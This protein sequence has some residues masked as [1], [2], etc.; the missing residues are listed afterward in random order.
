MSTTSPVA[1]RASLPSTPQQLPPPLE[2]LLRSATTYGWLVLLLTFAI[3]LYLPLAVA[4]INWIDNVQ[5]LWPVALL[6]V[7]V[8]VL[9]ALGRPHA[10]RGFVVGLVGG[11]LG[12]FTA[13]GD[14]IP[15]PARLAF[16][17][18]E[19]VRW[20]ISRGSAVPAGDNPPARMW[21][22]GSL[23]AQTFAGHL[24]S[25]WKLGGIGEA[26]ID[27]RIFLFLL[28]I[29]SWT[30][31]LYFAWALYSHTPPLVAV[32]PPGVVLVTFVVLGGQGGK[33]VYLFLFTALVLILRIHVLSLVRAWN[34]RNLD[35]PTTVGPEV[36]VT[37]LLFTVLV[38]GLALVL[39]AVPQNPLAVRFWGVFNGPWSKLETNVGEAFTGVRHHVGGNGSHDLFLG[40]PLSYGQNQVVM[41][42]TT[43]EPPPPD[44]SEHA[45]EAEGYVEPEH[46]LAGATY[47]DY[48]GKSWTLGKTAGVSRTGVPIGPSGAPEYLGA[49]VAGGSV[50]TLA[51]NQPVVTPVPSGDKVVQQIERVA[52]FGDSLLYAYNQAVTVNQ[53]T[54]VHSSGGLPDSID[55]K[56]GAKKYTVVSIEPGPSAQQLRA[57][58]TKYA[59]W[60]A[61]YLAKPNTPARVAQLAQQWAGTATNPYDRAMN[62]E[63]ELRKIP[64][65]TDITPPP[66]GQDAVDYFLFTLKRGYCEYYA[67]AMV[68]ML[69]D[70]GVPARVVTGYATTNYDRAKAAYEVD[71]SDAHAWV[72]IYFPNVGWL[73]FE[74]TPVN[75]ELVRPDSTLPDT[76]ISAIV[77]QRQPATQGSRLPVDPRAIA[78]VIVALLATLVT[79]TI[80]RQWEAEL[81]PR[82]YVR[83]VYGRMVRR[84]S[85]F[86]LRK[87][88]DETALEYGYRLAAEFELTAEPLALA[89]RQIATLYVLAQ[90]AGATAALGPTERTR[91]GDS[92]KLL[93]F[94]LWRLRR[95]RRP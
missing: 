25:W 4:D 8:G 88:P 91:A 16:D 39:P 43:D 2:M 76:S 31:I 70:V 53:P 77:A 51:A 74:P 67:S 80:R 6:A 84:S 10:V 95:R 21:S 45:L 12:I 71:D 59:A 40:G 44:Q 57:D 42:L 93:R 1:R 52:G 94:Q 50:Q 15:A 75:P 81:S 68:V 23:A 9:L 92:W 60:L 69:R 18:Q 13:V 73:D 36:L 34:A 47:A 66:S 32:L 61:P 28:A 82:D 19:T 86:G 62:I 89:A 20:A 49:S 22:A 56:P 29:V 48:N 5:I 3:A 33:Y 72:Q 54:T 46:Y 78:V 37:G 38:G 65:T 90:Y 17:A 55:L 24:L 27:N 7:V 58:S 85:R 26:T 11:L 63:G 79:V 83:V 87:D 35:Y 64:Y 14:V 30:V 41:Y